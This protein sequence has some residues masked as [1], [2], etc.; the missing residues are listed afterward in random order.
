MRGSSKYL[1][2]YGKPLI[3]D[4]T[5]SALQRRLAEKRAEQEYEEEHEVAS[6]ASAPRSEIIQA[7]DDQPYKSTGKPL[8]RTQSDV[9]KSLGSRK[10]SDLKT[11]VSSE[12]SSK[13]KGTKKAMQHFQNDRVPASNL[14]DNILAMED[15]GEVYKRN[16][17]QMKGYNR[18]RMAMISRNLQ[19]HQMNSAELDKLLEHIKVAPGIKRHNSLALQSIMLPHVKREMEDALHEQ[20]VR[21]G[22]AYHNATMPKPSTASKTL[23]VMKND[24]TADI[25]N[26][27]SRNEFNKFR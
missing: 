22:Q 9:S 15:L 3:A 23:N 21:T 12:G 16:V 24:Q 14:P 5:S 2:F 11:N 25:I 18:D 7:D 27:V 8:K 1:N 4:D 10:N 20:D 13:L 6:A 19:D 17:E 26:L